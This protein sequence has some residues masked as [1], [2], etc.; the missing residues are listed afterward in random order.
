MRVK[1]N[2]SRL[3]LVKSRDRCPCS[4][5]LDYIHRDLSNQVKCVQKALANHRKDSNSDA[6]LWDQANTDDDSE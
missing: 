1:G 3:T 5:K 4:A 6:K 2:K